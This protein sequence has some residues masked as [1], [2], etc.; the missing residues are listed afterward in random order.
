MALRL[1][2]QAPPRRA[3]SYPNALQPSAAA[4]EQ[5]PIP[6]DESTQWVVF[7]PSLAPSTTARTHTDST[8]RTAGASRVSDF[9]SFGA[10]TRSVFDLEGA[11]DDDD[12]RQEEN[13]D[14]EDGTELDSLDDGLHAFRAPSLIDEPSAARW[15][16][17]RVDNEYEYGQEEDPG[18]M[19]PGVLP[20]HDGLGSFQ[21]SSQTVQDRLWQHEQYNPQRHEPVLQLRRQSSVQRHLDTVAEQEQMSTGERERWQRIEKWRME[22]SRALLQEVERETRRKRRRSSRVNGTATSQASSSAHRHVQSES[23]RSVSERAESLA[24]SRPS[25]STESG[26]EAGSD[27]SFLK[28]ITRKVIR[29]LIGI[30]D[31]VLSVIFGESLPDDALAYDNGNDNDYRSARSPTTLDMNDLIRQELD[32]SA[33]DGRQNAWQTKLLQR[34]AHELG[35][36]VHQ[37]CEQPGAFTTYLNMS[38]EVRNEYAGMPLNRVAE[39]E[40]TT[41]AK[42]R[43][44]SSSVETHSEDP[45]LSPRFSPTLPE[46]SGREHAAQWGI[47]EDDPATEESIRL[48]EE[49]DYWEHELDIMKVFRYLRN[50]FGSNG[51][52]TN[53]NN[54]NTTGHRSSHSTPAATYMHSRRQAQ[55]ASRRAAIIRQHHPLV[56]QSQSRQS[57]S[58][59]AGAAAA[60]TG[61]SS[62]ILRQHFRR[63]SSSCAS[64]SAKLSTISSRR[65]MTGSS[66]NYWDIGGSVDSGSAVA[67]VGGVM[68]SWGD[69]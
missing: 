40:E 56:A 62:P 55:D 15:N 28:R 3:P 23:L 1:P 10:Q 54:N 46:P 68:G 27:E 7:S 67:P 14:D 58:T 34:I 17:N 35:V 42:P 12:S 49:R 16:N 60:T 33:S 25:Q 24:S 63:P 20:T 36:L 57:S 13:D 48:Q 6:D 50:R 30:D 59:N 19:T 29:D 5:P 64:Q 38:N 47:E 44:V 61:I 51:N 41:K 31:S 43:T 9:E 39:E 52:N 37:L 45:I 65:T 11:E 66:R 21:A 4:P 22:Q 32:S 26:T 8:E 69:V 18:Q 53:S 2:T